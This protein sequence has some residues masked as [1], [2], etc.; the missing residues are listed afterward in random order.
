MPGILGRG[1]EPAWAR[2]GR[3][4][5]ADAVDEGVGAH[6]EIDLR[7]AGEV[8]GAPG[9]LSRGS[10]RVRANNNEAAPHVVQTDQFRGRLWAAA[11]Y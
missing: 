2:L 7:G 1:V 8:R 6:D 4:S 10:R 11:T 3:L 9:G 5:T